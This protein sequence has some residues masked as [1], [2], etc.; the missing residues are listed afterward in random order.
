[1]LKSRQK[2]PGHRGYTIGS[3]LLFP[4]F[5]GATGTTINR[6]RGFNRKISD[7]F[8]L[9]LECIRR[10]YIGES[11]PLADNLAD[12]ADFFGLFENFAG[13]VD[14][15]LLGDLVDDGEV[16]FW[17]PFDNFASRAVPQSVDSYLSYSAA[18]ESFITARNERI[19]AYARGLPDDE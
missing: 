19:A 10:H 17:L 7:R 1:L 12:Y 2:L 8:D 3:A 6:A 15:W 18:R 13:Y 9:T 4:K 5:I 16:R 14:F 11:S